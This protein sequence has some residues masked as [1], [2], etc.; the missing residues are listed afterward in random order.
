MS[1]AGLRAAHKEIAA[2]D[3]KLVKLAGRVDAANESI[4]RH[5]Q[6][7]YE[8]LTQKIKELRA[9]QDETTELETRWLEL[10]EQVS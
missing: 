4:A 7:D 5:D 3:R 2:I 1:G 6:S 9:L 8:G 10:S